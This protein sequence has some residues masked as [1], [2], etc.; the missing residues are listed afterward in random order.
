MADKVYHVPFTK[1]QIE[2][3]IG[4][5]PIIEKVGNDAYWN[6]WDIVA[7]QYVRTEYPA[8]IGDLVDLQTQA[9]RAD[10]A[11]MRAAKSA[12]DAKLW[13]DQ[14]AEY[15]GSSGAAGAEPSELEDYSMEV[16]QFTNAA[17][18]W[19]TFK[20]REPFDAPPKVVLQPVNFAGIAQI[21]SITAEGFMYC[22]RKA[23]A[24]DGSVRAGSV[25]TGTIYT[26]AGTGTNPQHSAT[27]VVTGV[28]L[29]QVTL[30]AL[31]MNTTADKVVVNYIAIEY[32]GER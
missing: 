11:A 1:E 22:L 13:A 4:K 31:G 2:A 23:G 29:P 17:A 30:P 3:A 5:G 9:N 14:A 19:C 12:E 27:T 25:S 32:G 20:F 16:G 6:L 24:T 28:T 21:K 8:L 18:G 7:M 26:G 10:A 15:G